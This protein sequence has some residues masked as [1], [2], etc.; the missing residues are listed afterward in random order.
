MKRATRYCIREP[1][2][3]TEN[4]RAHI[5]RGYRIVPGKLQALHQIGELLC[6]N[7]YV[8]LHS[9]ISTPQDYARDHDFA[10][11]TDRNHNLG[12]IPQVRLE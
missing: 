6:R 4:A 1:S 9:D 3:D 5:S 8:G 2:I 7:E 12:M 11:I 10:I